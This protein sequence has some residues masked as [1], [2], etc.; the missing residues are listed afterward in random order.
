MTYRLI[1]LVCAATLAT[2]CGVPE[3]TR[4]DPD[5]TPWRLSDV[6][7]QAPVEPTPPVTPRPEDPASSV[8]SGYW[9]GPQHVGGCI[10]SVTWWEYTSDGE[11]SH[12]VLENNQC[13]PEEERGLFSCVGEWASS[14]WVDETKRT[15]QMD[16][17][18]TA[19]H[20]SSRVPKALSTSSPYHIVETDQGEALTQMV[21]SWRGD[22]LLQ[23][24][25]TDRAV[26]AP[27]LEGGRDDES[28]TM[29]HIQLYL[30]R[31]DANVVDSI[32]SLDELE[33]LQDGGMVRLQAVLFV[34]ARVTFSLTGEEV[35]GLEVFDV[36]ARVTRDEAGY[37]IAFEFGAGGWSGYLGEQGVFARHPVAAG[38]FVVAF[39]DTLH[40]DP[41]S[42][43]V[44]WAP[45]I[46]HHRDDRCWLSG[47]PQVDLTD[48]CAP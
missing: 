36:G 3:D 20:E 40:L 18:C 44:M 19:T 46:W 17:S 7:E 4:T 13:I 15:G 6:L 31:P 23:R 16:F 28:T 47:Y 32:D 14:D 24:R 26:Y 34:D 30:T 2:G 8:L 10:D 45:G 37:T 39:T 29:T 22:G 35:V 33:V 25:R 5:L 42:P 12:N 9:V 43:T 48:D 1:T 11:F 41:S 38:A 21:L 27:T